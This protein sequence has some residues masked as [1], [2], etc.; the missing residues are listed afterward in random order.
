MML[1][2]M[3]QSTHNRNFTGYTLPSSNTHQIFPAQFH[4][5]QPHIPSKLLGISIDTKNLG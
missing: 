2:K 5:T 3:S 1:K 4:S